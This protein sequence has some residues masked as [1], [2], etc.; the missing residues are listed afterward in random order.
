MTVW[1][2]APG[3]H[4]NANLPREETQNVCSHDREEDQT[5]DDE[6]D[7]QDHEENQVD[8]EGDAD[9]LFAASNRSTE[10]AGDQHSAVTC[11]EK[12]SNM[13]D[14]AV[15]E[16][17]ATGSSDGAN[18]II[19]PDDTQET[20]ISDILGCVGDGGSKRSEFKNFVSGMARSG[21]LPQDLQTV[22]DESTL[23][24]SSGSQS[25]AVLMFPG[26]SFSTDEDAA[27]LIAVSRH[28]R[29]CIERLQ[30]EEVQRQ[31][32]QRHLPPIT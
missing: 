21:R 16:V 19:N 3:L 9:I 1:Q 32:D 15:E 24:D 6:D 17:T 29:E 25:S 2:G 26:L 13:L 11:N 22:L 20:L 23:S 28:H 27:Q 8:E 18:H 14:D 31:L 30:N 10:P 5:D 4:C 12:E 7:S